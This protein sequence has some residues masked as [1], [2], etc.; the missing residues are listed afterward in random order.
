[1]LNKESS[2]KKLLKLFI[3]IKVEEYDK[4][5]LTFEFGQKNRVC[6]SYDTVLLSCSSLS[7]KDEHGRMMSPIQ[8]VIIGAHRVP[9]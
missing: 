8:S 7:A 5:N 1:M 2:Q 6:S 3:L 4:R 9:I